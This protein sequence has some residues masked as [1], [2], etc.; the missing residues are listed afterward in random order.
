MD[1]IRSPF[2]GMD[3]YLEARWRDVH[4]SLVLYTRD[5]IQSQVTPGLRAR[6]EDR[7]LLDA[8]LAD[9]AL[10]FYP[11]VRAVHRRPE[12]ARGPDNTMAMAAVAEP[13]VVEKVRERA[14]ETFVQL[15]DPL[16]DA[17]VVTVIEF[18]SPSNKVAGKDQDA[19]VA[20]QEQLRDAGV[21][22]VEVDLLRGGER[23]LQIR[24]RELPHYLRLHYAACASRATARPKDHYENYAFDLRH[25][26]P[27]IRIPLRKQDPDAHLDLQALVTK[28][29]ANG[30][31]D[32]IDYRKAMP[33]SPLD[34]ADAEWADALLRQAG[35]R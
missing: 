4:A 25:P 3:P 14:I 21:S 31:Y 10:W 35:K 11:D 6:V 13:H 34:A 22:L 20:K 9:D 12:P 23:V 30:G 24:P 26:L 8:P 5:Q 18:L 1:A 2:P 19:Y 27:A 7:V 32:D 15:I 29:Y 16:D 33:S 28:C 17:R